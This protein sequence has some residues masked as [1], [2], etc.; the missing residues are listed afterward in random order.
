ML[1][2]DTGSDWC[3]S[4][5]RLYG[6]SR[7]VRDDVKSMCSTCDGNIRKLS[8]ISRETKRHSIEI[9]KKIENQRFREDFEKVYKEICNKGRIG[10]VFRLL[11]PECDYILSE[12]IVDG[13]PIKNMDQAVMVMLFLEEKSM[14]KDTVTIWNNTVEVYGGPVVS[15][16]L[17]DMAKIEIQLGR[18][19]NVEGSSI[20]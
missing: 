4:I 1:I 18:L 15:E 7:I 2:E 11:H 9:P 3:E 20:F 5:K 13:V 10:K 17:E 6:I 8:R 19:K 14:I 12:C 16:T